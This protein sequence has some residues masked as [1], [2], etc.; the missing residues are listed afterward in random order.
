[1]NSPFPRSS[2]SEELLPAIQRL[3]R[4]AGDFGGESGGLRGIQVFGQLGVEALAVAQA[5]LGVVGGA[6]HHPDEFA[7][8]LVLAV[9]YALGEVA[10]GVDHPGLVEAGPL[11]LG[12]GLTPG[13]EPG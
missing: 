5:G 4:C 8:A 2:A 9:A 3:P 6:A 11:A 12:H 10:E 1:M 13:A 7:T